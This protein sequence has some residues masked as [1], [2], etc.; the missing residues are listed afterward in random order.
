MSDDQA[1][2]A[3]VAAYYTGKLRAHGAT[4]QGVDWR[5]AESQLRRF[6]QLFLLLRDHPG[7]TLADIG[8]GYGEL[9]RHIRSKGYGNRYVGV[10]IAEEMLAAAAAA[11]G[12]DGNASF[13]HGTLPL[14]PV[15]F[16]VASG[17][18]NLRF[19]FDT[20]SWETYVLAML[21][22]LNRSGRRG[23]AFNCLTAYSDPALMRSDLFYA[24]PATY[25]DLCKRRYSRQVALLHDYGLY[26][27]TIIVRKNEAEKA[28]DRADRPPG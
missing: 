16:A 23:F 15:D 26:E 9:L 1:I 5:D 17:I 2:I 27:F 6:D 10:D 19:G 20:G 12:G 4:P 18:F 14:E 11:H 13:E 7:G 25:F 3:T 21:D 8:C 28:I 22:G 24:D